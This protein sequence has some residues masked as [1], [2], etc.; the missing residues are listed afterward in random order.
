MEQYTDQSAY[1]TLKDHKENFKTKLPCRLINPAKSDIG[2]V[3]KG[4][5]EKIN[6]SITSQT[7]CNQW[8]NIQAVINW[9]KSI[10]N[11]TKA[12]LIKFDIIEFCP[13]IPEKLWDSAVSY[14]QT[15][16]II[17]NDVIQAIKQARKSL[18]FTEG[19][20]WMKKGE[21]P[22]FDVT[23]RSHDGAEVCEF[24]GIYLPGK[25]SNII[26]KEKIGLYRDDSLSVIENPNGPRR[27]RLRKDV[28][29]IFHNEGLK[30]TIDTN[31]TTIYNLDVTSDLFTGKYFPYK[32]PS[33]SLL[34]VN[35]NSNH[36]PKI[37]EQLPT[38]VNTCHYLS[39]RWNSI[40]Q[41]LHIKRL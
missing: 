26:D 21:N 11:K 17:P 15:L 3:S 18:L 33:D 34:Y 1:F 24:V 7:K 40:K 10:P 12:Q 13:S 8:R 22:L 6:R 14:A 25:L 23:M 20:I 38:M 2:L 31:L 35:A 27:D 32:K 28:I 19:N 29:A 41:N 9:F 39:M 36:P 16:S 5:L 37:L 30:I 4:E